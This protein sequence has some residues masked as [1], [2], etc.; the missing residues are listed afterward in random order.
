MLANGATDAAA[1]AAIG[2]H[3]RAIM[4]WPEAEN[5]EE[6]AERRNDAVE[7]ASTG[8]KM[9]RATALS[10]L[11]SAW[12]RSS[13]T[14]AGNAA[15]QPKPFRRASGQSSFRCERP[16]SLAPCKYFLPRG[17]DVHRPAGPYQN[18]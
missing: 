17:I 14:S 12:G 3:R 13:V 10:D 4:K 7:E 1:A 5:D 16:R 15:I 9:G 2:A 8:W 18:G 11:S 6:F